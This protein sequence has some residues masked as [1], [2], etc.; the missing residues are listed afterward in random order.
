MSNFKYPIVLFGKTGS[1]KTTIAKELEKLGVERLI[2]YTTRPR[3][4]DEQ[5]GVD[6]HFV[7]EDEFFNMVDRGRIAELTSRNVGGVAYYYGTAVENYGVSHPSVCIMDL[8]GIRTLKVMGI[9]HTAVLLNVS[10][11][12]AQ[13]RCF[14]RGDDS[15]ETEKRLKLER[16]TFASAPKIADKVLDANAPVHV[17]TEQLQSIIGD[18]LSGWD[19]VYFKKDGAF[20]VIYGMKKAE[21]KVQSILGYVHGVTG[22]T[23]FLNQK[24]ANDPRVKKVVEEAKSEILAAHPF[25]LHW[26]E[27][28]MKSKFNRYSTEELMRIGLTDAQIKRIQSFQ[29]TIG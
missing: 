6:Y 7:S 13:A 17:V 1:G 15:E 5:D 28:F 14:H 3:R 16:M 20:Y 8:N 23:V 18:D 4:D 25:S 19:H 27:F 12:Y 2:S 22:D 26:M 24:T 10:T 9:P 21:P 29:S 11:E